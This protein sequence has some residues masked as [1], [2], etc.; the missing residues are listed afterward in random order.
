MKNNLQGINSTV[1]EAKKQKSNLEY[2]KGKKNP[3]RITK[4]KCNPKK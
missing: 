1:D 4:R 2:N 3:I